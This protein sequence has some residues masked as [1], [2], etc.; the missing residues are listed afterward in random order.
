M[1]EKIRWLVRVGD[2]SF[3]VEVEDAEELVEVART[4]Y[5]T[6][7]GGAPVHPKSPEREFLEQLM[8]EQDEPGTV[9]FVRVPQD[10]NMSFDAVDWDFDLFLAGEIS[11]TLLKDV[12]EG[13]R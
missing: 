7:K 2:V 9:Q 1:G 8:A 3:V 10:F 5:L 13:R 6:I 4:Q 11:A 12:R